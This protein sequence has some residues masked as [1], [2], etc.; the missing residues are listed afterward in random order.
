MATHS[1]ILAWRIPWTEEPDRLQSMGSQRV[2]HDWSDLAAA[3][4]S[5]LETFCLYQAYLVFGWFLFFF[6]SFDHLQLFIQDKFIS[7]RNIS[8]S[9]GTV[10]TILVLQTNQCFSKSFPNV[11]AYQWSLTS[12]LYLVI[13][14][15]LHKASVLFSSF[16]RLFPSVYKYLQYP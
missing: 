15:F 4:A 7:L 14:F 6:N 5:V 16:C 12:L 9:S 10:T 11:L 8:M 13:L 3:A 1:S 2:R